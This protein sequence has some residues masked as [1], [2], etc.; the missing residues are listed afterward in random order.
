[1][2]ILVS[3][4]GVLSHKDKP[5]QSGVDMVKAMML[6]SRVTILANEE[7]VERLEV[8][9]GVHRMNGVGDLRS[10]TTRPGLGSILQRQI[11]EFRANGEVVDAV[12]HSDISLVAW[13]MSQRISSLL[14]GDAGVTPPKDRPDDAA[15]VMTW[16]QIEAEFASRQDKMRVEKE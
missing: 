5:V 4:D 16:A 14:F 6:G 10:G 8:F 11:D 12:I 15:G 7:P 2:Q 1:V 3:F 9:A 13:L